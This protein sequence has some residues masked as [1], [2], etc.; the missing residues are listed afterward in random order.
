MS[1]L[2]LIIADDHSMVRQGVKGVIAAQ[3]SWELCGEADNGLAAIELAK[4]V[5]PDVAVLDISMPG[6]NGLM[7]C[8][9]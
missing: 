4:R 9:S 2:R 5:K 3:R 6:L 8:A 1:K 7:L